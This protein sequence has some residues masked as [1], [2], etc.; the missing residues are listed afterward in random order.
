MIIKEACVGSIEAAIEAEKMGADRLEICERLDIGGITPSETFL[1]RA[2]SLVS[3]P[4]VVMI[5]PRGGG[6]IYNPHELELMVENIYRCKALG[7][8]G[9][10]LGTLTHGGKINMPQMRKL[11]NAAKGMSVTFHMAFDEVHDMSESM[12][13]LIELG[14]DR[15]LTRGGERSALEGSATIRR[16]VE[17][18]EGR[19]GIMPGGGV[20]RENY[21]K[22]TQSTGT[23]EV[24]GTKIV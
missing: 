6:F 13:R 24:H 19:I 1:E 21:I 17:L 22:L 20:T 23:R 7:Y 10:A 14:V 15:I 12:K 2:A 16:M 5:R 9:V 11:M 4:I 3:L 18:S 8:Y